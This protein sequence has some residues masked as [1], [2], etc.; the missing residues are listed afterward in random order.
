M[1]DD[2]VK[3]QWLKIDYEYNKE[4]NIRKCCCAAIL[5]NLCLF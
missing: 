3:R 1:A 2:M 5:T 4:R